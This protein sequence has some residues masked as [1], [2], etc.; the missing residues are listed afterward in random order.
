MAVSLP[1]LRHTLRVYGMLSGATVVALSLYIFIT[2][3]WGGVQGFV[4][5]LWNLC[6]RRRSW[7]PLGTARARPRRSRMR[8]VGAIALPYP[9]AGSLA[10]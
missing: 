8:H 5:R 4:S 7:A 6:A 2:L 9:A 3:S 1:Y 10:S